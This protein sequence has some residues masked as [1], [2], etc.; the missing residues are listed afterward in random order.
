[1][2]NISEL[3]KAYFNIDNCPEYYEGYYIPNKRWNGWA[4]P[5][6]TKKISDMIIKRVQS[7]DLKISY[8]KE[9][10]SYKVIEYVNNEV[11]DTYSFEKV[12]INTPD[13]KKSLYGIGA[14]YWVW[15]DYSLDEIDNPNANIFLNNNKKYEKS[16]FTTEF[17]KIFY[18]GYHIPNKKDKWAKP[19]FTKE[20]ADILAKDIDGYYEQLIYDKEKDRYVYQSVDTDEI[21]IFKKAT[22]QTSEGVKDVYGI[23]AGS[24][25]WE[26]KSLEEINPNVIII[27][28]DN[29]KSLSK[30]DSM[31]YD[32]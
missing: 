10:D 23:G 8:D 11:D 22:I 29:L 13:G 18:E 21:N 28:Q 4:M 1:M 31:D 24:W 17:D 15:D 5:Y 3:K 9:A 2:I 6:F 7:D 26:N 20:I 12:I 14:G 27:K 25:I 30:D 19:Y 16:Y 32:Y